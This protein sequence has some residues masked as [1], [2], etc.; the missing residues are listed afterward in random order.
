MPLTDRPVHILLVDQRAGALDAWRA[1]DSWGAQQEIATCKTVTDAASR[2]G[3]EPVD[4]VVLQA[5]ADLEDVTAAVGS[6]KAGAHEVPI[7]VLDTVDEHN[8]LR[9]IQAGAD[10]AL[11][12]GWAPDALRRAVRHAAL[13]ARARLADD[14]A[15]DRAHRDR[16]LGG[17]TSLCGPS[18]VPVTE[19]SFG[20]EA[21][22]EAVPAQHAEVVKAYASLLDT[23]VQRLGLK[24]DGD[25]DERV[26][27]VADRLGQMGAG[28]RDVVDLHKAVLAAHLRQQPARRA[29]AQIEEG[30]LLMVQLMGYLVSY[31]RKQSWG[32]RPM[33]NGNA[34]GVRDVL[35]AARAKGESG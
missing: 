8:G 35:L 20:A 30:R 27:A 6:L 32:L 7:V 15:A 29:R 34:V 23:K 26:H 10:D 9:A 3:K 21:L 2:L 33:P 1:A 4:V 18:P 31:Y 19:R 22:R 25:F 14:D 24:L 11:C 5:G 16:E 13:R 28:P 12:V 17:L